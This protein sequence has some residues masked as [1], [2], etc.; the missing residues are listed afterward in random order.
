L[1]RNLIAT[2]G[3]ELAAPHRAGPEHSV[4]NAGNK[5]LVAASSTGQ[6]EVKLLPEPKP[7]CS[8]W[9]EPENEEPFP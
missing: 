7:A 4:A 1:V 3:A 2:I 8:Q 6:R 5:T 9:K